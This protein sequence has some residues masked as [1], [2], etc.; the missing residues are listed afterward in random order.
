MDAPT[1]L[2]LATLITT[3][4]GLVAIVI[5]Q[6][7]QAS[8]LLTAAR[9]VE[10]AVADDA[11]KKDAK[12]EGIHDLVNGQHGEALKEIRDLKK[13]LKAALKRRVVRK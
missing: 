11:E 6:R 3:T 10:K 8:A 7:F 12:L 9:K 4:G 2:T 1:S 13:E 5:N